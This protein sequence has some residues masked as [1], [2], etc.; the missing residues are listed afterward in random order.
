M[1]TERQAVGA[2]GERVAAKHLEAEGLVILERNWR[3][4][5]GE[6][7]L[8]LRDGD[9]IVFCEVKTRRGGRFGTPAEAV[10][11]RKVLKLRHLANRYMR[12]SGVRAREM[13]FDVIEVLLPPRGAHR[14]EHIRSAF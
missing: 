12:E 13:R 10:V 6:L 5:D 9:D 7:D 14:V 2:Y 8:V 1:T 11:H 3:C 4:S